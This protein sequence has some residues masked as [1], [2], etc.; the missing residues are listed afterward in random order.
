MADYTALVEA[1]NALVE[2]LRDNLTPEPISNREVIS[3]CSPHESENNQLTLSLYQV[4]EDTQAVASGYYQVDQHTQRIRPAKYHLRF[5]VTA[6]SK[7]PTQMKEADQY[8]MIGAA[9]QVL[10]DH[11]TIDQ[12]YLTGSL[13]EQGAAIH[14]VLEK[15]SQDQLLKIWNNT[16][17]P[18]KLSFVVL[19]TGIE[20]DSKRERKISRVTDVT[21][22][23][24]EKTMEGL[25]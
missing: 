15:T 8:R 10:K 12:Q 21:I 7:A 1:G 3:L 18:Y 13:A 20:I 22:V 23:M 17:K 5:L 16:S 9:L 25:K 19:L 24:Q 4:E 11:P 14:V 2:L 6:H